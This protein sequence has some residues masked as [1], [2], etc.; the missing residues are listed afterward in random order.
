[1]KY[2]SLGKSKDPSRND[3]IQGTVPSSNSYVALLWLPMDTAEIL[4]KAFYNTTAVFGCED[5]RVIIWTLPT[6][7]CKSQSDSCS[8]FLV[9]IWEMVCND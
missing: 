2:M 9:D 6:S 5:C 1:M 8:T 3:Y 7:I 4:E